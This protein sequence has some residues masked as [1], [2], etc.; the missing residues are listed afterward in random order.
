MRGYQRRVI[1]LK[2]TGSALFDEAMLN[3]LNTVFS[4]MAQPLVL[5]LALDERPVSAEL[6][7]YME[8][9]TGLTDKLSLE[10]MDYGCIAI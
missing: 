6:K 10:I 5:K 3:Q 4:R 2:N 9:L 1:Y 8:E 7:G